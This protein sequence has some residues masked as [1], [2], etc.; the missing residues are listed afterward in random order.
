MAYSVEIWTLLLVLFVFNYAGKWAR[1]LKQ[2]GIVALALIVFGGFIIAGTTL[3]AAARPTITYGFSELDR[4]ITSDFWDQL[5]PG[6]EVFDPAQWRATVLTGRLTRSAISSNV[7]LPLWEDMRENPRLEDF[8]DQGYGY[9]YVDESWWLE[10][11]PSGRDS[12]SSSC[13]KILAEYQ[14][15]SGELRRLVD[16]TGC[17]P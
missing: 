13:V 10:M 15:E 3:T 6:S 4:N 7:P 5:P 9:I 1:Q 8:L 14:A 2:L 11:P 12:L 16:I 17:K